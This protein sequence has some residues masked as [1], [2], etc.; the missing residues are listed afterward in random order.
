[1][2]WYHHPEI[3]L[4]GIIGAGGMLLFLAVLYAI[5]VIPCAVG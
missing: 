3:V 1:M 2:K 5:H 4:A